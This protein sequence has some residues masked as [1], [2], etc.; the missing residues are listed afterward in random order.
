VCGALWRWLRK[1]APAPPLLSAWPLPRWPHG[2]E[3]VNQPL[4]PRGLAA[5]RRS[6]QR[7]SPFGASY[8]RFRRY[9]IACGTSASGSSLGWH[10][11]VKYPRYS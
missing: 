4:T 2:V 5:G 8:A 9:L 10:C 6:I 1:A 7:G 11:T 3:K